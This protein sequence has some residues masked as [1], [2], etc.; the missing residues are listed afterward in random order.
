M[1]ADVDFSMCRQAALSRGAVVPDIMTQ[2]EFLMQ[3]G[4]VQR[5]EQLFALDS[6]TEEQGDALIES[7][8]YLVEPQQMGQ[9]FKVMTILSPKISSRV[10]MQQNVEIDCHQQQQQQQEAK[11]QQQIKD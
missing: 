5:I 2:G 3:M 6:T 7:L 11:D 4:I 1:T 8:K 10:A 9:K